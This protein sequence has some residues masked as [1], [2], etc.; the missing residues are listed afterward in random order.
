VGVEKKEG[1]MKK[2]KRGESGFVCFSST[3]CYKVPIKF[4]DSMIEISGD[5]CC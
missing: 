2:R 1:R 4:C 3:Y 5:G